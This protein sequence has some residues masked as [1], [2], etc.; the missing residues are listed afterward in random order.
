MAILIRAH[1]KLALNIIGKKEFD[2]EPNLLTRTL[3]FDAIKTKVKPT[4][5]GNLGPSINTFYHTVAKILTP[6]ILA[7]KIILHLKVY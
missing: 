7:F 6:E 4:L 1:E 5:F 3:E 2:L